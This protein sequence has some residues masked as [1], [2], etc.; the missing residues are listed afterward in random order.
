MS[1]FIFECID[2]KKH[3]VPGD[4]EYL[5]PTCAIKQKEMEPLRGLLKCIYDYEKVLKVFN[6]KSVKG[7]GER[8]PARYLELLPIESPTSIPPLITDLTP[9]R[10]AQKIGHDLGLDEVWIKDD[11]CLPTGSFKD[12]ASSMVVAIAKEK[13]IDTIATASTGNAAVALAGMAASAEMQ[14]VI[15]VPE[16]APKAKLT[17]IAVYGGKLIPIKGN[18]DQAFE[19]SIKAC[20]EFGWYNRNTGYNPFTVEGKKTAALEIWEQMF[21]SV[22]DWV[23]VPTGDG[24]ILAG[25]EKGFS[26]LREMGLI[27]HLPKLAVVQAEGC[28]PIVD[29]IDQNTGKIFPELNPKTIADSISVGV[30]RAGRWVMEALK[31]CG[32]KAIS[33][34]D[35]EIVDAIRYLGNTMGIFCEP[36]AAAAVAGLRKLANENVIEHND[37]VVVLV[38]GNGLKDIPAASKGIEFPEAVKPEVDVIK[39]LV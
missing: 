34:T 1:K 15:F 28:K 20:E 39:G 21:F 2:C 17:Q 19:L 23:V 29:A 24:V 30:P 37:R 12:R 25:I 6:P 38:T 8:G 27:D 18:Y 9:L 31:S 13:E 3:Y 35:D 4:V 14:S 11:T 33:V 16:S 7:K 10:L 26:D 22:P 36:A 5:C 32:G